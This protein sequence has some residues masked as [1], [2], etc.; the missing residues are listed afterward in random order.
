MVIDF[1][2][3]KS[4]ID[5]GCGLGVWLS[6]FMEQG[7]EDI[8]GVDGDYVDLDSIV[9]PKDAFYSHDLTNPIK[10]EKSLILSFHLRSQSIPHLSMQKTL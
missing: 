6:I 5:V 4:V 2:K 8:L 7:I 9:I 3:P 1:F 10:I